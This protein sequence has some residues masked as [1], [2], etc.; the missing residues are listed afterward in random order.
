MSRIEEAL[1]RAG[2]RR[3]VEAAPGGSDD[4]RAHN[5][6]HAHVETPV[7]SAWHLERLPAEAGAQ[8]RE[9]GAQARGECAEAPNPGAQ[10]AEVPQ[11]TDIL[12]D[13]PLLHPPVAH[14]RP[15]FSPA[16]AEKLVVMKE[17]SRLSLE[18]Y[19]KAAAT[20]HQIQLERGSKIVMVAS[21]V[22]G[23]GKTLTAVNLALT[24]SESYRRRV[25]LVDADLRRPQLH[26]VFQVPSVAGLNDG[27]KSPEEQRLS[28]I[29]ISSRLVLLPAGRPDPDPMS[30]LTSQRMR[31]VLQEAA[32]TFDWVIMDTPPVV[33]LPDTSLLADMVDLAVVVAAAARTPYA[34]IARAVELIGRERIAGIILN[35]VEESVVAATAGVAYGSRY[36]AH[37][38][39][40]PTEA[41]TA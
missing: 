24:L 41:N 21:A 8:V 1:R 20:L 2:T 34:M 39:Q 7:V 40:Q 25:L 14:S 10:A 17:T 28:T 22:A 4:E 35:G 36:Y 15:A 16:V 29:E 32:A 37:T 5:R 31:H 27:L 13:E 3:G 11:R 23:E 18:Q 30:L 26:E 9:A 12:A 6:Q 19:R 33:Q 38:V